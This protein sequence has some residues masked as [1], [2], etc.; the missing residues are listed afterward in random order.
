[1]INALVSKSNAED[2]ENWK[3]IKPDRNWM[4]IKKKAFIEQKKRDFE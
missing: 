1:M 2:V 3:D 4:G